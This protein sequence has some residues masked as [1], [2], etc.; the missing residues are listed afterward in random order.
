MYL[1]CDL[2]CFSYFIY[3]SRETAAAENGLQNGTNGIDTGDDG[4]YELFGQMDTHIK[5]QVKS[6]VLNS[7]FSEWDY[8]NMSRVMRKLVF[9]ICENKDADQ[10]C[11]NR[12]ADQRLCFSLN[13]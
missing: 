4:K 13:K 7:K 5:N 1:S 2:C 11:S 9:H 8:F 6:L 12:T 3:P 10:L